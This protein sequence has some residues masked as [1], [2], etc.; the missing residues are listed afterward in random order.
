[1]L[2][3]FGRALVLRALGMAAPLGAQRRP[4]LSI[5]AGV[6]RGIG[7][8]EGERANRG[9]PAVDAVLAWRMRPSAGAG[10]VAAADFLWQGHRGETAWCEARPDGS[11]VLSYPSFTAL[12]LLRGWEVARG[13]RVEGGCR[14]V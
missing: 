11:C 7:R 13:Q 10:P 8:G 5:E 3:H 12:E 2:G 14:R 9:A 4:P 6:G 1:M